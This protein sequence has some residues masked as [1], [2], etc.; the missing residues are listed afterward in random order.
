MQGRHITLLVVA[1]TAIGLILYD[2]LALG[3]WGVDSTISVVINEW[4]YQANPL[5]VF[6]LGMVAGGL[7]VHFLAWKPSNEKP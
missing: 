3:F 4:V 6:C 7:V 2:F 5:F 1:L